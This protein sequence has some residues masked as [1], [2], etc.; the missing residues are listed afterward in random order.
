MCSDRILQLRDA[1]VFEVIDHQVPAV[2]LS[3]VNESSLAIALDK[4]GVGVANINEV[5]L[6]I[7]VEID[8][9]K[10]IRDLT[11]SNGMRH[12]G[13]SALKIRGSTLHRVNDFAN[14]IRC[15]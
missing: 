4:D 8:R 13:E 2:V 3:G 6:E 7:P 11:G 9:I 1:L 5:N 15:Q 12:R 10:R 14:E